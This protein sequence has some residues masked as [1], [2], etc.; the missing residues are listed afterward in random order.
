MYGKLVL[1]RETSP[2]VLESGRPMELGFG[3]VPEE[4]ASFGRWMGGG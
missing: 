4:G 1:R 3:L 2:G